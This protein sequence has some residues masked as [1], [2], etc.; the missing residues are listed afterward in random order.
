MLKIF[1]AT[2]IVATLLSA[3]VFACGW[4]GDGEGDD[5]ESIDI[6]ADGQPI[7]EKAS[8]SNQP[9]EM[10]PKHSLYRG[11]VVPAPRA[12]FGMVVQRDGQARPYLDVVGGKPVYSIQQLRQSGFPAVIDLGTSPKVATLHRQET[13]TLGMKY[14]NIPMKGDVAAKTDVSQF[15]K[16]L[17]TKENLPILIFSSSANRLGGMWAQYRLLGGLARE[18]AIKEGKRFGLSRKLETQ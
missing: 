2:A 16:I 10:T 5:T 8:P 3:P 14:F 1:T 13:E 6:G 4:W 18:D 11:L 9:N 7:S 15:Q 12:G 17:T